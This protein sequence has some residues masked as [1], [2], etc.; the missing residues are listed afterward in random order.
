MA[1]K[2]SWR[3]QFKKSPKAARTDRDGTVFDSLSELR[4][5]K[6]LQLWQ[7]AGEIRC[8]R[9]QVS[10][11]LVVPGG[12]PI[13]SPKGK[14]VSYVADFVYERITSSVAKP[15]A[16]IEMVWVEVIEEHKGYFSEA[17]RLKVAVF[18]AIYDRKVLIT[19]GK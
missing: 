14:T 1:E 15:T 6:D 13:L 2:K 9:R 18:E 10:Y 16:P 3:Q 12:R 4:R 19:K 8:L 11:E 5:W 7:I 17:A